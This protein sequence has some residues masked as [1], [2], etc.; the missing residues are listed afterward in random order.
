ML[1]HADVA[2]FRH[3]HERR[4]HEQ[5]ELDELAAY[6]S[7]CDAF[8]AAFVRANR[9]SV[10]PGHTYRQAVRAPCAIQLEVTA[11]WRAHKTITLVRSAQGFAALAGVFSDPD[12]PSEFSLRIR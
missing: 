12:A 7:L 8:A 1:A 11:E 3:L 10:R 9:V 5:L 6:E 2:R 4:K